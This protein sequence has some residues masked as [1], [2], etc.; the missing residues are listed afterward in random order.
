MLPSR[1]GRNGEMS[2]A[3]KIIQDDECGY[4]VFRANAD[5]TRRPLPLSGSLGADRFQ[6]IFVKESSSQTVPS[7]RC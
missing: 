4:A 2:V 3:L 5:T 7:L 6:Y 1:Y